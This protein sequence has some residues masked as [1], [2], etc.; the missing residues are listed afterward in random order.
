MKIDLHE[1]PFI[2]LFV[3]YPKD[4]PPCHSGMCSIMFIVALIVIARSWKQTTCPTIEE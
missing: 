2:L 3:I 4:V 1:D